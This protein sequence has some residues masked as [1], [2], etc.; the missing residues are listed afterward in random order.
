[1]HLHLTQCI[2]SP[3]IQASG[4]AI[5]GRGPFFSPGGLAPDQML[6]AWQ[7]FVLLFIIGL[8]FM[9]RTTQS[10]TPQYQE[11]IAVRFIGV[12]GGQ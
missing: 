9:Y 7:I 3:S 6:S 5:K 8:P 2:N 10:Q 4:Q 11:Q 1:M 12:W